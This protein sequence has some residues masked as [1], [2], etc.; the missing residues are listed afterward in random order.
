MLR[1]LAYLLCR[2]FEFV[3]GIATV[4]LAVGLGRMVWIG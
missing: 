1:V 2:V 4:Q 3:L